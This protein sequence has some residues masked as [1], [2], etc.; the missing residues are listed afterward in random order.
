MMVTLDGFTVAEDGDLS[1]TAS[2]DPTSPS[3]GGPAERMG[4]DLPEA[5]TRMKQEA[6]KDIALFAGASVASSFMDLDLVDEYRLMVFPV[7]LGAGHRLFG[8]RTPTPVPAARRHAL[9]SLWHRDLRSKP[10][11][12]GR[13]AE[14][15]LLHS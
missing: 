4:P 8:S 10:V 7:T 12:A 13:G 6:A 14:R 15:C 3:I 5:V 11:Y 2:H 1:W 9:R